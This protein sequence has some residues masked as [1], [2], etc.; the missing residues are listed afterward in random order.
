MSRS[1]EQIAEQNPAK[2]IASFASELTFDDIPDEA[3][4]L[5]ER[6]FIDT[7]GVTLVG[8]T[9]GA[10]KTAISVIDSLS[11]GGDNRL[12]A[13]GG[14]ATVTDAAFANGTAS[15]GIDFDDVSPG[16]GHPSP[17]LVSAI[18]AAGEAED[19]SGKDAIVAYIAGFE[20]QQYLAAA[21]SDS[22]YARGWHSTS[23]FGTFGSTVAVGTLLGLDQTKLAHALNIAASMPAG[24]KKNFGSMTKPMHVGNAA[25]A[26][27][28]AA[29]LANDGFTAADAAVGDDGGFL[30]LY[31]GGTPPDMTAFHSLGDEWMILERGVNVKKY[32]C[33]YFT[34]TSIAGAQYLVNEYDIEPQDIQHVDVLTTEAA[35]GALHYADP[36]T[37]LEGKFSMEYT[38]ASAI[39]RERVGLE[40]FDDENIDDAPVQAIR[41]VVD[42]RVDDSIQSGESTVTIET[43]D[44]NSYT[45]T[46]DEPPGTH[47][48]PLTDDEL[49]EKF[50][51]CADRA[52]D[53]DTAQS[54]YS[55]LNS[56]RDQS[57]LTSILDNLQ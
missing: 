7:V 17:P 16:V 37:G 42:F 12:I 29:Y 50:L 18:L 10:G 26:G 47:S 40:A 19:V 23:T 4:R 38:V 57:R 8:T 36:D 2:D 1:T 52:I 30:D 33:C 27:I 9:E 24:L 43:N 54:A 22:H 56:L 25:R 48:N 6:C 41:E 13:S 46:Q 39:A 31:C 53:Q 21:I 3:V 45:H 28:S 15:H 51:M 11:D 14:R 20:T 5:T 44:G 34:H 49:K 55:Q 35:K 32:P